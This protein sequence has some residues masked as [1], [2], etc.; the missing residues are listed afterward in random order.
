MTTQEA[1]VK[2]LVKEMG[3][4]LKLR[5]HSRIK[6]IRNRLEYLSD[7]KYH[8]LEQRI[9]SNGWISSMKTKLGL[10]KHSMKT[11][12]AKKRMKEILLKMEK[13]P[14]EKITTSSFKKKLQ[15][16]TKKRPS[17]TLVREIRKANGY[18]TTLDSKTKSQ[19]KWVRKTE[20]K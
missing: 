15:K 4:W 19:Q 10:T 1:E 14:F 9:W 5:P 8:S 3:V 16:I 2:Q 6:D 13:D 12:G 20:Q 7:T 18:R 17:R 11:A